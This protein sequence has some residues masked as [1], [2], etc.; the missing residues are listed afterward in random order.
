MVMLSEL[1]PMQLMDRYKN[2]LNTCEKAWVTDDMQYLVLLNHV[3]DFKHVRIIHVL[4]LRQDDFHTFQ[5]I[6]DAVLGEGTIAVQVYP[7]KED[8]VDG[9]NTYH[10]WSWDGLDKAAPNLRAMP[11]YH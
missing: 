10:L 2:Q 1:I 3:S 6:K 7:R 11:K 9:S 4:G 8:V 5:D